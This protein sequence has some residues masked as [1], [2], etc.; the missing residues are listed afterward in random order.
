MIDSHCHFDLPEFAD[1]HAN[2]LSR[3]Q[4]LGIERILIPG[5]SIAQFSTL[6]DLKRRMTEPND[7]GVKLASP[8][9]TK[10]Q[11]A[12][13]LD[14]CLG[15]HPFF[16]KALQAS[17]LLEQENQ[18][19]RL[20]EKHHND[21]V[22]IGECGLDGS[23]PIPMTYQETVLLQ[24]IKLAMHLGKPLVM[25]HRQSHNELIRVLKKT[26][27]SFGGII[28]AFSGSEQIAQSYIDMGFLLGVGGTITY[29]RAVKTRNTIAKT[30]L[31]HLVL[32]TDAPDMPLNGFQG[33]PNSPEKLPLVAQSLA[34][35]KKLSL[36]E[37]ISH[38]SDNY[39][40]LFF[41]EGNN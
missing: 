19:F 35:L 5:L 2:V 16:L 10:R 32:E 37:V 34:D 9:S 1:K 13:S 3:C 33:S 7:S 22:A 30:G 36:D 29:P 27:F 8:S 15:L 20:G 18:V 40:R 12:I 23:L 39:R 28:H 41:P 11:H 21:I 4:A 38:T 25:H 24:Q 31:R 14:I 17:Q 6:R 26:K